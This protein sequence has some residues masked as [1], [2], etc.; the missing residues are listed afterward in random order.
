MRQ[1]LTNKYE[2]QEHKSFLVVSRN[3][4]LLPELTPEELKEAIFGFAWDIWGREF[5]TYTGE[6][7]HLGHGTPK[8]TIGAVRKRFD[9]GRAFLKLSI[10]AKQYRNG[11]HI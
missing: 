4:E 9:F 2:D 6:W 8:P 3:R 10:A 11:W 5:A 1:P 7:D